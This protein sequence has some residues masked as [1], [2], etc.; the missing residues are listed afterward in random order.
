MDFL[1]SP[2]EEALRQEATEFVHREWR[3]GGKDAHSLIVASYD[4]DDPGEQERMH[5][6]ARKL[7]TKGW[8]TMHWPKEFGGWGAP[9]ST[10]LAYREA[11]A[12]AG[13]PE[14]LGGGMFAPMLMLHGADWQRDFF[15]PKIASGE[16]HHLSQGFSEPNAGSD[17]A[18]VQTRAVEDGDDYVL[19]GQKIWNSEG[20]W[21]DWGHYLVRTDPN[22]PKHRGISYFIVDMKDPGVTLRPLHDGLGRWRWSEVFLEDVRVPKRNLIGELNRGFYTAM[23]TLS[24][25][26][27]QVEIPARLMN[28]MEQFI[29]TYRQRRRA[30]GSSLLDDPVARHKLADLRVQV[31]TTRMLCYRVAWLQT[32]GLVPDK[33]ASM[34]KV[35]GDEVGWRVYNV[36]AQLAGD[37]ATYLPRATKRAPMGGFLAANAWLIRGLAVGGGT[38]EVQRNIIAQRGLDLPR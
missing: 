28:Y 36:L 8:Y 38:D 30:T 5:D 34:V 14:I 12:Y 27:S 11:M 10:Q 31:E 17:L 4:V 21:S 32:Q 23:T 33:E 9:L 13:A 25:E 1:F 15:L 7:A 2:E 3:D 26:R 29:A 19:N 22:A 6:F 16:I 18:N 35:M 20:R 24:F 37:E